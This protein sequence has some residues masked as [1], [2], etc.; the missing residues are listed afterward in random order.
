MADGPPRYRL[1]WITWNEA[2]EPNTVLSACA[3]KIGHSEAFRLPIARLS[4]LGSVG[5]NRFSDQFAISL[6]TAGCLLSI[7]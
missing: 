1:D 6:G 4:P 7:D 5:F 3:G 2:N